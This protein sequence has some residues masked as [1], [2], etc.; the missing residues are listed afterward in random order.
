MSE[1][2]FSKAARGTEGWLL[3]RSSEMTYKPAPFASEDVR[4]PGWRMELMGAK[5][6]VLITSLIFVS[7]ADFGFSWFESP[8]EP[9]PRPWRQSW[10]MLQPRFTA[11]N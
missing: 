2:M 3:K 10:Q 9:L 7:I 4:V 6:I 8:R 5:S 11:R 1:R